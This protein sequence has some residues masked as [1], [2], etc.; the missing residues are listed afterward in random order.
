MKISNELRKKLVRASE[1]EAFI[2]VF[3]ETEDCTSQAE[4]SAALSKEICTEIYEFMRLVTMAG[5]LR[6]RHDPREAVHEGIAHASVGV[7]FEAQLCYF[8]PAEMNVM[9]IDITPFSFVSLTPRETSAPVF[10]QSGAEA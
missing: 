9:E 6:F 10:Q 2:K 7:E 1:L 8:D 3:G 4:E 5:L